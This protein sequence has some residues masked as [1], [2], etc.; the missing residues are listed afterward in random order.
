MLMNFYI[1]M[2]WSELGG[3]KLI[4]TCLE[5]NWKKDMCN[6]IEKSDGSRLKYDH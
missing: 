3:K 1:S 6:W 2:F 4:Y 5:L